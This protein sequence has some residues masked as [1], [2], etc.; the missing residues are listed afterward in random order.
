ML[1]YKI[2]LENSYDNLVDEIISYYHTNN[3]TIEENKLIVDPMNGLKD[4]K[5]VNYENPY[6]A[7]LITQ[8]KLS[9]SLPSVIEEYIRMLNVGDNIDVV[10]ES[11]ELEVYNIKKNI[12]SNLS[13]WELLLDH[14]DDERIIEINSNPK[15]HG[16]FLIKDLLWLRKCEEKQTR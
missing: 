13:E 7:Y 8:I 16:D 6:E 5:D 9:E 1:T 11:F 12:Y 2:Y 3:R 14:I 10:L 15:G 4:L